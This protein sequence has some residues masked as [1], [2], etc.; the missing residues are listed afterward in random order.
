MEWT[1]VPDVV[2][3]SVKQRTKLRRLMA[4]VDSG[5][6]PCYVSEDGPWF[7]KFNGIDPSWWLLAEYT[8]VNYAFYHINK[9]LRVFP[10]AIGNL[11][12]EW[13]DFRRATRIAA[14]IS[15]RSDRRRL[16][17]VLERAD[18]LYPYDEYDWVQL[19]GE[20]PEPNA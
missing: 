1:P 6:I 9:D 20:W 16:G 4:K 18:R 12:L 3:E 7:V 5:Y 13:L 11:I 17:N 10:M 14:R 19:T 2:L 8:Q 15:I